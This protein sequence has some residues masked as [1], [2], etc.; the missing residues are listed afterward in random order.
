MTA[1]EI[2]Y[3]EIKKAIV[4]G[5]LTPGKRVSQVKLAK[6]LNCSTIPIVEA[7][8]RLESEGL[9]VKEGRKMAIVRKFTLA[10]LEGLYLLREGMEVIGARLCARKINEE[11][12]V[13]LLKLVTQCEEAALAQN[14]GVVQELEVEIHRFIVKCADCPLLEEELNRL[15]LIERTLVSV[16]YCILPDSRYTHRMLAEAILDHEEDSAEHFMKKHI[17]RGVAEIMSRQ[18][19]RASSSRRPRRTSQPQV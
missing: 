13:A 3:Q 5:E 18:R 11:Q 1:S 4:S 2:A 15:L 17:Q 7:L 16:G 6:K 12:G 19:V 9:L 8:R 14:G 10:E